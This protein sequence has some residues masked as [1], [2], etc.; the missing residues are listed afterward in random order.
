MPLGSEAPEM[1]MLVRMV[2]VMVVVVAE[3]TRCGAPWQ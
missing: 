3:M 2:E 1:V